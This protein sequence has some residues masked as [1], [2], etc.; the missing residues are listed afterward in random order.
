MLSLADFKQK[1]PELKSLFK[2]YQLTSVAAFKG[3]DSPYDLY[4]NFLIDDPTHGSLMHGP[5][6]A[7]LKN[8]LSKVLNCEVSVAYLSEHNSDVQSY[9]NQ[10]AVKLYDMKTAVVFEQIEKQLDDHFGNIIFADV[11]LARNVEYGMTNE[12]FY[13]PP[14][15]QDAGMTHQNDS[16][17]TDL[18]EGMKLLVLNSPSKQK[19]K[20]AIKKIEQTLEEV[21]NVLGLTGDESE[22]QG[23]G[24]SHGGGDECRRS[25]LG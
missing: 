19:Q 10:N 15:S 17:I 7:S 9:I 8:D 22:S 4:V 24:A 20:E 14:I 1:L 12:G 5:D 23:L 6:I 3:L 21:K 2:S 25:G 18:C 11:Q 13:Y 16:D